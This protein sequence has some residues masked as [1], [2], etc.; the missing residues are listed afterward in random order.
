MAQKK[1][2]HQI[3]FGRV[4]ASIWAN[5]DQKEN[6]WFNVVIERRYR[7]GGEWK[8]TNSFGDGDLLYVFF[9]AE[10]ARYWMRKHYDRRQRQCGSRSKVRRWIDGVFRKRRLNSLRS[11]RR[12]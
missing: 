8:D 2:V 11:L 3:R 12:Q 9:I 1:P 10:W 5:V 4:H 6:V 7:D